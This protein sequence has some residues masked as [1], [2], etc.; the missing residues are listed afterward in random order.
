MKA[1]TIFKLLEAGDFG[2][3]D[4]NEKKTFTG[5]A[6]KNTFVSEIRGLLHVIGSILHE[7]EA[8]NKSDDTDHYRLRTLYRR[9]LSRWFREHYETIKDAATSLSKHGSALKRISRIPIFSQPYETSPFTKSQGF[10]ML[11]DNIPQA[12]RQLNEPQLSKDYIDSF[13]KMI[14]FVKQFVI[15]DGGSESYYTVKN[16]ESLPKIGETGKVYFV[17]SNKTKY[18]WDGK[19]Y[20]ETDEHVSTRINDQS[21]NF[22]FNVMDPDYHEKIAQHTGLVGDQTNQFDQEISKTM[23]SLKPHERAFIKKILVQVPLIDKQK[24]MDIAT[25]FVAL[26]DSARSTLIKSISSFKHPEIQFEKFEEFMKFNNTPKMGASTKNEN[27]NVLLLNTLNNDMKSKNNYFDPKEKYDL[28]LKMTRE[29]LAFSYEDV[30]NKFNSLDM[31]VQGIIIKKLKTTSRSLT[32]EMNDAL[33]QRGVIED[34]N[35]PKPITNPTEMVG[36]LDKKYRALG[37]ILLVNTPKD[38]RMEVMTHFAD[39]PN[40]AKDKIVDA[41]ANTDPSMAFPTF[42]NELNKLKK[43]TP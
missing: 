16:Y 18:K 43:S 17:K 2:D 27:I 11:H 4:Q 9:L 14:S 21:D 24:R 42:V 34:P 41:I 20:N 5:L 30:I 28:L 8:A 32:Y 35:S 3:F 38:K 22:I 39:L 23:E 6:S 12:L 26:D 40:D 33:I 31:A 19:T 29:Q 25:S 15:L 1:T 37:H 13:N 36:K 10:W 7:Y